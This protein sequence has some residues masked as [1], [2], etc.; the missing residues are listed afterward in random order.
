MIPQSAPTKQLF[1]MFQSL[2]SVD[3]VGG[4]DVVPLM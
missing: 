1:A 2:R 4:V 3:D